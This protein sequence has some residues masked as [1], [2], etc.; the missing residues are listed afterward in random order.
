MPYLEQKSANVEQTLIEI[1][2]YLYYVP[3][4]F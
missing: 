4:A 1:C 2:V 3:P